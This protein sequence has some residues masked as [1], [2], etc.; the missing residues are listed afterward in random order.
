MLDKIIHD[1]E[2]KK[3][4]TDF[5]AGRT[6][7][8][9]GDDSQD[10]YI[11]ASGRVEVL[12]GNK[13]IREIAKEGELFGEMS[14]L[15]GDRRTASV[16]ATDDVKVIRVPKEELTAFLSEFPNVGQEI[17]K[18]LARRLDEASKI[19]YGL[20]EFTDQLPDAVVMTDREGNVLT[21]NVAAEE[22]YGRDRHQMGHTTVEDIYEDF[23]GY[24]ELLEEVQTRQSVR[25]KTL[26]IKHPENGAHFVSTSTT[27][28]YDAHR[29]FQ[30]V[31]SIGRDVTEVKKLERRYRRTRYWLL[32][33]LFLLALMIA[34]IFY[35]YP[36]FTKGFQST[37]LKNQDLRNQLAKDYLLLH[38]LLSERYSAGKEKETQRLMREFFD[39]QETRAMPYHGLVLLDND[40][41]AILTYSRSDPDHK[42]ILGTTY[43]GISFKGSEN[44]LHKVL[45][46]YRTD[47]KH[48]MGYKNVEL[49]FE[50]NLKDRFIG[51]LLFQ[52]DMDFIQRVYG[53]DEKDLEKFR[54][55]KSN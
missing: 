21:W 37:D 47:E 7:F 10:L 51:W 12:K 41:K 48:P 29:N 33:S 49:G 44:S 11:L 39:I 34:F 5:K 15:L 16:K 28:L 13:I 53:M 43:S 2:L 23:E 22:L 35:G 52:M 17:T 40:K 14:F 31:L 24:K 46:L 42:R 54:F 1:P 9:E 45:V 3:Y 30:G 18:I 6:I 19:L 50:L 8:M 38:S 26:R 25:E 20:K 27:L 55:K 4:L 36:Y 32:P